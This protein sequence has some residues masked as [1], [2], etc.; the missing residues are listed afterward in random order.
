MASYCTELIF[1]LQPVQFLVTNSNEPLSYHKDFF[2]LW[3]HQ[4][5]RHL[6]IF[7]V[8]RSR[9][10]APVAR[11]ILRH[12]GI[13][14]MLFLV[15]LTLIL[16]TTEVS[17]LPYHHDRHSPSTISEVSTLTGLNQALIDPFCS[18]ILAHAILLFSKDP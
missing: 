4:V 9:K 16:S 13:E 8:F 17:Q 2:F 10:V 11:I 7:G 3:P 1:K 15:V 14:E 12:P 6:Y 18:L 5:H